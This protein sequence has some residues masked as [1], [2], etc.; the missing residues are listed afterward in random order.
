MNEDIFDTKVNVELT[1]GEL[2]SIILC[3]SIVNEHNPNHAI[4]RLAE[5]LSNLA[6]D[7]K[8]EEYYKWIER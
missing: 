5:R 4:D 7:I 6:V 1:L 2:E 3:L 8:M